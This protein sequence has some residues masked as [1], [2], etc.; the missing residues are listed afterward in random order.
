MGQWLMLSLVELEIQ[1]KI[2]AASKFHTFV[3]I[4]IGGDET[5]SAY[6]QYVQGIQPN[7]TSHTTFIE[8]YRQSPVKHQP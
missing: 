2:P 3:L 1:I 7:V 5:R 8:I 6:M 4:F